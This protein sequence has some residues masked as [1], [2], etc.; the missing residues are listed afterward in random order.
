[1]RRDYLP[2]YG[3][4]L[5]VFGFLAVWPVLGPVI[6]V[7]YSKQGLNA[8]GGGRPEIPPSQYALALQWQPAQDYYWLFIGRAILG[9]T[10]ALL[11]DEL[12]QAYSL[13]NRPDESVAAYQRAIALDPAYPPPLARLGDWYRQQNQPDRAIPLYEQAIK[14]DPAQ[15]SLYRVLA[16]QLAKIGR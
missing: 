12:G 2:L 13:A 6:A 7:I 3:L 9:L 11:Y 1:V 15:V 8:D 14:A 4:F 5:I 10:Q 16:E